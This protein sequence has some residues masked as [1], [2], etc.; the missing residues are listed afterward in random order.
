MALLLDPRNG[1]I[2][3]MASVPTF[4]PNHF[5]DSPAE[6]WRNRPVMDAFEPG[7]TFKIVT[8]A[9][10]LE[11]NAVGPLD[12]FDCE[13]GA[14]VV[15]GTRI[16]DHKR[17]GILT[18][19][20]VMV[21]SSNVGAIKTGLLAGGAA[22]DAQMR[23]FGFGE[24][25][26]V[27]LPGENPGIVPRL[28]SPLATAYASFG[29]SVS[30]TGLQLAAATAAVAN[31]GTLYRPYIV[32]ALKGADGEVERTEPEAVGRP[33]SAATVLTLGRLLE[34]VVEEGTGKLAAV[35]GYRVAGKTGTAQVAVP[36]GYS[37]DRHIASFV[38]FAPARDPVL[39]G[40]V[41]I[42][43]PKGATHGGDVAA[44]VFGAVFRQ[45][46]VY[47]GVPAER[48]LPGVW[49]QVRSAAPPVNETPVLVAREPADEGAIPDFTGMT[50]REALVRSSRLGVTPRFTGMGFVSR[51]Q[52]PAGTPLQDGDTLELWLAGG[53]R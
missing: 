28:R 8:A 50:A 27:D 3:A 7:S 33:I 38:G 30:V 34:G 19:R 4:D 10:A 12:V 51:Q 20:E 53:S 24:R 1:A 13:M 23:A 32:A 25:T 17:F 6:S 16:H 37:R 21:N 42:D 5:D 31:G 11:A 18:F 2:L 47:L 41:V 43:G 14:T 35:P 46:L 9:A 44:P 39:L 49:P 40:L 52:P 48:D 29:Q 22:L 15:D 26:G 36:G 45:A